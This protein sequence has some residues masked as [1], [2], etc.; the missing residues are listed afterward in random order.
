M[1]LIGRRRYISAWMGALIALS[2]PAVAQPIA[3][4]KIGEMELKLLGLSATVDPPHPVVPKNIP[5][6]VRIVVKAGSAELPLADALRFLG[7]GL[8]VRG[9]ASGP[10]LRETL[11][12][13][14]LTAG[15]PPPA[16][17]FLLSLPGLSVSGNYTLANLRIESEGRPVLDVTPQTVTI[18]VI[19]QVL[20]TSVKTRAL[21][22]DEIR[23]KGIVLDSDDYLGFEFT[24]GLKLESQ[25]VTLAFPVVFDRQGVPIPDPLTPPPSPVRPGVPMPTMVPL[26]LEAFDDTPGSDGG[27]GQRLPMTLPNG[28]PVRIPAVL[29]IPGNVGYLKQFFSAQLFVANG[30]PVG[31]GLTV[32]SVTGTVKLPPGADHE[33]GTDDDPLALPETVRG[34]QPETLPILG[35]GPDGKAGTADDDGRFAPG[36]QGQA[37]F[38]LRGEREG[39]HTLDF[40]IAAVLEGLVSGPVTIKGKAS[41]GLLVR[42]PFFDMTF[43]VPSVVRRGERF[44]LYASVTN[45]GQG[46]ANDVTVSLDA[47]ALSGARLVS[48]QTVHIDTLHTGDS[49]T[50]AFELESQKTGQVVASYLKL[51]GPAQSGGTLRF[52]LGVGERGVPLSPDTLVL[53]AAVDDVPSTALEAA[54]RVLGQAWS[55][56][57]APSG[58]L[59]RGVLRTSKSVVVAKALALAEAG[60]RIGLGQDAA[61]S[62]EALDYDFFAGSPRD[63]GFDQLLHDTDAG[64]ALREVFGGPAPTEE[65]V[66]AGGPRLVAASVIGPEVLAGAG[67]FGLHG[68]LVFDRILDGDSASVATRYL[69]PSNTVRSAK[70]V[71]SG[72][73]VV[74]TLTQ[75]EGPYVP[76]TIAVDGLL[77]L[78]GRR[79]GGYAELGA[80]LEDPG[81]VV[82]GR[83]LGADGTPVRTANVVYTN[84][85]DFACAFPRPTGVASTPVDRDGRFEYRYVRRDN[86]GQPFELVTQDPGTGAVR[87][88]TGFVRAAGERIVLDIVLLG[89]GS[90][91][92]LVRDLAGRPVPGAQ[93]VA[94]SGSDPQSGGQAVTD[95]QGH[96]RIDGITVG[97]VNVKA[98][99]GIALGRAAGRIDRAGTVSAVDVVLDGGAARVSGTVRRLDGAV[100][101]TVPGVGVVYGIDPAPYPTPV[102]YVKTGPDGRFHFEAMPAGVVQLSTSLDTGETAS[103]ALFTVAAGDDVQGKDLLVVTQPAAQTGTVEGV[104]LQ[105]EGAPAVQALVSVNSRGVLTANDGSFVLP[106]LEVKP[107]QSQSLSAASRDGKRV[108]ASAFQLNSAGDVAH[109]A[110]TLSG[111]GNARF[112]VIDPAGVPLA[113]QEVRIVSGSC[114]D[115]C[116]CSIRTTGSD[117][118]VVYE[119][120]PLGNLNVQAIR[121]MGTGY[122][123][124]TTSASVVR[125]GE[126][127]SGVLRFSGLGV[128]SGTVTDPEGRLALGADV[129]MVSRQFYNDGFFCGMVTRESHRS[130]TAIDGRFRFTGVGTGPVSL[131][132]RQDFYPT[133]ATALGT[134]TSGSQELSFALQL[135][136]TTAGVLSGTVFLPDGLTP[137]GRGV[138]VTATGGLP[139][140]AVETNDQGQYHFARIFPEGSYRLTLNDPVTGDKA[141][142]REYLRAGQDLVQNIRLKG[143]GTVRVTVVD[144]ADQPVASAYV[145]LQETDFP[146]RSYEAAVES[147]QPGMALIEG[148]YE[149]PFSVEA[150]D[151]FARGGR[152]SGAMPRADEV[153]D[154]KLRLT[155]TGTVRGRFLMPDAVTTIPFGAIK[156]T[157]GNKPIGQITT[158]G[159]GDVGRFSFDYVP[160]GPVRLDGEDPLTGRTGVAVGGIESE[161]QVLE[162]DV[163]A[164]ALGSV[165]GVVTSNG[166]AQAAAN[167]E[168]VSGGYKAVTLA[169]GTGR[170]LVRGVPAGRVVVTASLGGGFLQ[171]TASGNLESEGSTLALDVALRGS[172]HVSGQVLAA[173]GVT[174]G[175][176]S[177]VRLVVGGP[178]GGQLTAV[179]QAEGRFTFDRVPAGQASLE[180]DVVSSI[181]AG[182]AQAV[183]PS[184]GSVDVPIRLR[185]V[186][187]LRGHALDSSGLPTAGFLSVTAS[188]GPL[189]LVVGNDG[190]FEWP[191]VPAGP[192]SALLRVSSGAFALYGSASGE[193]RP[194]EVTDF[195]VQVQPSGTV[196]G[197]V[198]RPDGVTPAYGAQVTVRLAAGPQ[199]TVQSQADGRFTARGVPLGALSISANDPV[200]AGLAVLLGRNLAING[201]ILDVGT[202]VL[203]ASPPVLTPVEPA[204]GSVRAAFGGP[205]VVDVADAGGVD[206]STIAIVQPRAAL[207]APFAWT[208]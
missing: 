111:L 15:D 157:A 96:Y 57:N 112:T 119:G 196:I 28:D 9:D 5:S 37:E 115:A 143:R 208:P 130:R 100:E 81:A 39:F 24:L 141:Q 201:Q 137:A 105:P 188:G 181:D 156:L 180:A 74:L 139:D 79:G 29:V 132:A 68:I 168:V 197:V 52:S 167:V 94:L 36:E 145:K 11:S 50:V 124:V 175:P 189:S 46:I 48:D 73:L 173:D 174:P 120:L 129:S 114:P 97:P 116:G 53:P 205:L 33:P 78:R 184:G 30:A 91:E 86:C 19:D 64:Q 22:L 131:S 54:M 90:V 121:D 102:G 55:V 165:E 72:R 152:G 160:A 61:G 169:D 95:G 10:G 88:S 136:D 150:S 25:P 89:R 113:G 31:S 18:E 135:K 45:I 7:P 66:T 153:V 199:I 6:A 127:G 148:V 59:P 1:A 185:G 177:M 123:A 103:S 27:A 93:V 32:K 176:L 3:Y 203:D 193:V 134:L 142:V 200:S 99:K 80:R 76:T 84:N 20:V 144:G 178:G 14:L 83:V 58:T 192:F 146:N 138:L 47:A 87:K 44:K 2:V 41:G 23:E 43:T 151:V 42:N 109:V 69:I 172:G 106:G 186:G 128:V 101:T 159:S 171:G 65:P 187:V 166:N 204:P 122:E 104:V 133:P 17:P 164:Q 149:G 206:P 118:T 110:I 82:T 161:G 207:R 56:A 126:T 12:L 62:L 198:L 194:G 190:S 38:L 162:L 13:P 155:S 8:R 26:L 191:E 163:M 125:D 77:D 158:A 195:Q 108:G 75:P 63:L 60:L 70:A 85:A 182:Q 140:V 67:P 21:T 202:L 170:F 98:G 35:L 4:R 49:R 40:D 107:G 34:I 147:S 179:T 183:V 51:E 154:L 92:G 71:L 117:G 16:D